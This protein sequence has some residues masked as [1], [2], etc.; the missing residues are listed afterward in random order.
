MLRGGTYK[1]LDREGLVL[2]TILI[3]V[4]FKLNVLVSVTLSLQKVFALEVVKRSNQRG[5]DIS[6][7]SPDELD[8]LIELAI[9]AVKRVF[10]E[11]EFRFLPKLAEPAFGW[12]TLSCCA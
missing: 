3:A 4:L 7:I 9:V 8:Q 12:N 2:R 10:K 6:T 1:A 11:N 5:I